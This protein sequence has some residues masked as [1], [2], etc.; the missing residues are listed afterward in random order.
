MYDLLKS[1][2]LALLS[3]ATTLSANESF[4]RAHR[5]KHSLLFTQKFTFYCFV[6]CASLL[7]VHGCKHLHLFDSIRNDSLAWSRW[8]TLLVVRVSSLRQRDSTRERS[9]PKCV[10]AHSSLARNRPIG[11]KCHR[12]CHYAFA[13]PNRSHEI[14][15]WSKSATLPPIAFVC[16]TCNSTKNL[17]T[18][19]RVHCVCVCV[20]SLHAR[21]VYRASVRR[22]VS[23]RAQNRQD[24]SIFYYSSSLMSIRLKLR[25]IYFSIEIRRTVVQVPC[26]TAIVQLKEP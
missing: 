3:I 17:K 23:A 9:L 6:H 25:L 7:Q 16:V 2:F 22:W 20:C 14:A 4:T 21:A 13:S 8:F 11:V 12:E 10:C 24:N 18:L 15:L 26:D 5:H 19:Y 1:I